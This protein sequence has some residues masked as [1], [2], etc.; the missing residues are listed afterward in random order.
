MRTKA[1]KLSDFKLSKAAERGFLLN[2]YRFGA[3]ANAPSYDATQASEQFAA[4][5]SF[6][7]TF[8]PTKDISGRL[9]L[10]FMATQSAS[11][12]AS[13][14]W[15]RI[16]TSTGGTITKAVF[17]RFATGATTLTVTASASQQASA[18]VIWIDDANVT[19]PLSCMIGFG[20]TTTQPNPIVHRDTRGVSENL[21]IAWMARPS[22]SGTITAGPSGYAD[23]LTFTSPTYHTGLAFIQQNT[24]SEDPG[25]FTTSNSVAALA[26]TLCIYPATKS[27]TTPGI[28]L[29]AGD[30]ATI[31]MEADRAAYR[32]YNATATQTR[33]RSNETHSGGTGK[34]YFEVHV[35]AG[36]NLGTNFA[37]G[38]VNNTAPAL[39]SPTTQTGEWWYFENGTKYHTG[40]GNVAFGTG[41]NRDA[42]IGVAVDLTAGNLWFALNNVWQAS[43]DPGAGTN[44]AFTGAA[45]QAGTF[46]AAAVLFTTGR[47][48]RFLGKSSECFYSPPSGFSNWS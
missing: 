17:W 47:G 22:S 3:G 19:V 10:V 32:N 13:A 30:A 41:Y 26:S 40:T 12:T 25:F 24:D 31:L 28:T 2:P 4:A 6:N 43:G 5:T 11:L 8:D 39:Q 38:L 20:V 14:G 29:N 18:K 42:V 33:R 7:I 46:R 36:Q 9:V 23:F 48:V 1:R 34:W 27:L 44:P 45:L 21:Y 15:S 35:T 37:I 16:V